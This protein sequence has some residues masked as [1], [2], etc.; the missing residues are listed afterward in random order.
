MTRIIIAYIS[1]L[2]LTGCY[3]GKY[4]RGKSYSGPALYRAAFSKN[5]NK[6]AFIYAKD[7][8]NIKGLYITDISGKSTKLLVEACIDIHTVPTF[9]SDD[10]WII[11]YTEKGQF[12]KVNTLNSEVV[13]ISNEINPSG[14]IRTQI[15]AVNISLNGQVIKFQKNNCSLICSSSCLPSLFVLEPYSGAIESYFFPS[16]HYFKNAWGQL[17][18]NG[19][20]VY[21]ESN[22]N[23]YALD[24]ASRKIEKLTDIISTKLSSLLINFAISSD[25]NQIAY[26]ANKGIYGVN[27]RTQTTRIIFD[28][29]NQKL[30]IDNIKFSPDGKYLFFNMTSMLFESKKYYGFYRLDLKSEK[31]KLISVNQAIFYDISPCSQLILYRIFRNDRS[32]YYISNIDGSNKKE[33]ILRPAS[34][35]CATP[36]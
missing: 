15:S 32:S 23:I 22:N 2:L 11:Y 3:P 5:D 30:S 8:Q 35:T 21:F 17:S 34:R 12:F 10:K 33:I 29:K 4:L 25:G 9:T 6:I 36:K 20:I 24:L 13:P 26:I 16:K 19:D 18:P 28:A 31:L 27:T 14:E 1:L 7:A